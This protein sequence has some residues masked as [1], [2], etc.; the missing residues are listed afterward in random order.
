MIEHFRK[1]PVVVAAARLTEDNARDVA[2]WCDGVVVE[3]GVAIPTLEGTMLAFPGDYVVR[4][5][6]G[7]F[8]PIKADI[9][10]ATYDKVEAPK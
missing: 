3:G 1:K 2:R 10:A 5:V 4:G 8:Y 6:K 7:E 9:L